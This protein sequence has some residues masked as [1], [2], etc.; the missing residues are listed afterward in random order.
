MK[1]SYS[2]LVDEIIATDMNDRQ[3]QAIYKKNPSQSKQLRKTVELTKTL[4]KLHDVRLD[5]K[6]TFHGLIEQLKID[7]TI[8]VHSQQ[9]QTRTQGFAHWFV[10]KTR[11]YVPMAAV[12]LLVLLG[13]AW[14]V[15]TRS[16]PGDSTSSNGQ[17]QISANGSVANANSAVMQDNLTEQKTATADDG[18]VDI[19]TAST[20][21]LQKLG[22][23]T[24]ANF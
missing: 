16:N 10:N 5:D 19:Y 17:S 8:D 23:S 20:A 4:A 15:S 11:V 21:K 7:D 6:Q 14:V 3:L 22:D 12:L 18:S 9:P 24:D 1:R 13:G 2:N